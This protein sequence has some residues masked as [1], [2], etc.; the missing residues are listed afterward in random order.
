MYDFLM[1][2]TVYDSFANPAPTLGPGRSNLQ[3]LR[4]LT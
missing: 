1:E 2:I 3:N 4:E